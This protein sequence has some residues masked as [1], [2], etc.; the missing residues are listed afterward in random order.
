MAAARTIV[1]ILEH[2]SDEIHELWLDRFI[3]QT[4]SRIAEESDVAK[5]SFIAAWVGEQYYRRAAVA[6]R[7]MVD[8]HKDSDSLINVMLLVES[9]PPSARIDPVDVRADIDALDAAAEQ[10]RKYVNKY[11]AHIDRAP[12]QPI[13]AIEVVDTAVQMLGDLLKKYTLL[14]R[15]VDL[16]VDPIVLFDWTSVFK[17]AWLAE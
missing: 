15:N 9:N 5:G 11:L 12:S 16:R 13:P 6:V 17:R 14:I 8:R 7:A 2:V 1:D 10:V 3:W 4:F